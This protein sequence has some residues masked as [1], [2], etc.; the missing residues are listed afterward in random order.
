[1]HAR[2]CFPH[3][4]I[5][6][7]VLGACASDR[8]TG[9]IGRDGSYVNRGYGFAVLLSKLEDRWAVP[10]QV[11]GFD[12]PIDVD[13]DGLIELDETRRI[14][15]P[16]LRLESKTSS[17]SISVDVLIFGK[18]N[19]DVTLDG[20]ALLE[21]AKLSTQ[22]SSTSSAAV[23]LENITVGSFPARVADVPP[24]RRLVLIDVQDFIAE[25]NQSRR[26]I[27]TVLLRAQEITTDLKRDLDL[28]LSTLAINRR[29]GSETA[30]EKW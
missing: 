22:T 24:E 21:I 17:A 12:S 8:Y 6:M 5:G 30:Q 7:L 4:L 16:T 13:G 20:I 3:C 28:L 26:Q 2:R 25:E 15:R 29:G 10:D 18:N 11:N 14:R 19:K 23:Q 1:M 9:S 27:F